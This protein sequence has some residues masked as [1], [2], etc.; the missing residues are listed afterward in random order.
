MWTSEILH[1]NNQV[2]KMIFDF[3]NQI[4]IVADCKEKTLIRYH[5]KI[6]M[7]E[8]ESDFQID[9]LNELLKFTSEELQWKLSTPTRE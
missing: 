2:S 9:K 7:Q 6:M 5:G 1:E 3:D 8:Y 4:T